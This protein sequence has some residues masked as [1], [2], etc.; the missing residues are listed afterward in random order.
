M[1]K[2][3]IETQ[4]VISVVRKDF[5][6]LLAPDIDYFVDLMDGNESYRSAITTGADSFDSLIMTLKLHRDVFWN[7]AVFTVEGD[8]IVSSAV[9]ENGVVCVWDAN[10]GSLLSQINCDRGSILYCCVDKAGKII[11]TGQEDN[12]VRTWNA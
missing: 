8:R 2:T 9:T 10:T 1:L 11:A 7:N 6:I 3:C 5:N 4:P 12:T